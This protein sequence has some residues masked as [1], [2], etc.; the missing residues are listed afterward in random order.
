VSEAEKP[1]YE[2]EKPTMVGEEW[3]SVLVM[4]AGDMDMLAELQDNQLLSSLLKPVAG[5]VAFETPIMKVFIA[6]DGRI[7]AGAVSLSH[8]QKLAN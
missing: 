6:N 4:P 5:G 1:N 3:D 7:F 2:G 8:L